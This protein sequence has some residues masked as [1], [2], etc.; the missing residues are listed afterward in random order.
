MS[1]ADAGGAA[2]D[3]TVA[4]GGPL[5]PDQ[6]ARHRRQMAATYAD[7]A[8]QAVTNVR[9]TIKDLERSLPGRDK[10]GAKGARAHIR[11]L[12]SSLKGRE[13]DAKRLRAEAKEGTP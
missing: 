3:A 6:E 1:T 10:E 8:E 12:R 5:T 2:H 9:R 11:S 4:I 7:E 13:A